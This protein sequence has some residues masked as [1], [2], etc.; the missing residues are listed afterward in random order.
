MGSTELH[1]F[2]GYC[3]LLD[4]VISHKCLFFFFNPRDH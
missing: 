3:N 1:D 4:F 2:F